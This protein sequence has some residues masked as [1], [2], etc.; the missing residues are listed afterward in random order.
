MDRNHIDAHVEDLLAASWRGSAADSFRECWDAWLIGA[1]N[2]IEG[3]DAMSSLLAAT[4]A[5]YAHQDDDSEQRLR[6]VAGRI[7][8]RLG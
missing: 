5:D 4:Q 7:V 3:L 1:A 8:E 2:V 6:S